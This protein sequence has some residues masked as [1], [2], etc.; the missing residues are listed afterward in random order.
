MDLE[1]GYDLFKQYCNPSLALRAELTGQPHR[2]VRVNEDGELVDRHAGVVED[3]ITGWGTQVF[4]HR[5]PHVVARLQAFLASDAP[6]FYSSGVSAPAGLL[7]AELCERTGYGR[8]WLASGGTEAVEGALKLARAATGRSRVLYLD[9]AYHGCTF[10]SVSMMEAGDFRDAFG[11]GV[12]GFERLPFGDPDALNSA[13]GAG[14]VA[15]VVVEPI[16]VEGGVRALEDA[17]IEALA[18]MT[19]E[20][21]ALLVADEIQCGL[22]RTGRFLASETWPRR[23]DVLCLG[24]ALGGGLMPVSAMLTTDVIFD[25]AY[26]DFGSS[27]SH[28]STFSGS[29][30]A[31]IAG[32][33]TL[34]LLTTDALAQVGAATLGEEL[35]RV[36]D[37]FPQLV[38]AVRGA[39]LLW[40]IELVELDHPYLS[41]EYLGLDDFGDRP[42]ASLVLA[43]RLYRRGYITAVCGHDWR[44]L[45][46]QPRLDVSTASIDRFVAVLREELAWLAEL[47]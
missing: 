31:A 35:G 37:E 8:V 38:R 41:F 9:G 22:G 46:L 45:R 16:Q 10:G 40:G 44:T 25:A 5:N 2:Y 19:A 39:G 43:H 17:Y 12:Q 1:R 29:G 36:R 34:E 33:A 4:G 47:A 27:E 3:W 13:L 26:G 24:K 23:P 42:A 14:D 21:G 28:N 20:H 7:A 6:T 11:A 18:S 32:L 15:A 30:L